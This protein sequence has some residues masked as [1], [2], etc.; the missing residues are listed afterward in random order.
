MKITYVSG[1]LDNKSKAYS[2]ITG[3]NEIK[4][5]PGFKRQEYQYISSLGPDI[6][7]KHF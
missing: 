7:Q 2:E 5:R 1:E 4:I 6:D 3:S